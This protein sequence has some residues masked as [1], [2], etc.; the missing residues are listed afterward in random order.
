MEKNNKL[1]YPL[2]IFEIFKLTTLKCNS[3][4]K[5]GKLEKTSQKLKTPLMHKSRLFE[6]E[7][8][9]KKNGLIMVIPSFEI[10]LSVKRKSHWKE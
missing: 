10:G 8:P 4:S 7:K 9:W 5:V 3:V 2:Q 1:V 6:R